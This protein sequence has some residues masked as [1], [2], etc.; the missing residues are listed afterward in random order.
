MQG[1]SLIING[2]NTGLQ[3][4]G[5]TVLPGATGAAYNQ[6]LT[7][8]AGTQGGSSSSSTTTGS[9]TTGMQTNPGNGGNGGGNWLSEPLTPGEILLVVVAFLAFIGLIYIL[10]N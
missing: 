10:F 9:S 3:D 5:A 4:S 1:Y 2:Q 6:L 8:A 7:V